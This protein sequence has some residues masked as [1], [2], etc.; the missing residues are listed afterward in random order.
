MAAEAR[1]DVGRNVCMALLISLILFN[2]MQ[3]VA[4][5]YYCPV[6][7][8]T[9]HLTAQDATA[10]RHVSGK[11][12]F[13]VD[14]ISFYGFFRGLESKTNGFVPAVS[15]LSGDFSVLPV[16]FLIPTAHAKLLL[17]RSFRLHT[18]KNNF[19]IIDFKPK[20]FKCQ[21]SRLFITCIKLHS[22]RSEIGSSQSINKSIR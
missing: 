22:G 11:W 3:I 8:G 5:N 6:H 20:Y 17:E 18:N 13:M 4:A 2:V 19:Y 1:G 10:D 21:A 16:Y 14:V 12:A 15:T 7:L 9:L